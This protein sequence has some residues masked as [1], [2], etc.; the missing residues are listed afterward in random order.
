MEKAAE[1]S[2]E[3]M[4]K[5]IS[6]SGS[7]E[8]PEFKKSMQDS[9]LSET[10][11]GYLTIEANSDSSPNLTFYSK[12]TSDYIVLSSIEKRFNEIFRLKTLD[13]LGISPDIAKEINKKVEMKTFKI[14]ETG[15]SEDKG[16]GFIIAFAM[17]FIIYMSTFI[18]GLNC[19]AECHGGKAKPYC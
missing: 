17:G 1:E 13:R 11:F 14:S 10:V 19:H 2:T 8:L 9:L 4:L 7:A 16:F 18:Y 3:K 6:Y 15:E 12:S 5:L